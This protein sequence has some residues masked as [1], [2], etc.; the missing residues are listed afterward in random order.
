MFGGSPVTEKCVREIGGGGY[1]E[2]ALEA[3]K[4]AKS[5]FKQK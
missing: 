4:V 3:V 2:N 1:A 5:L